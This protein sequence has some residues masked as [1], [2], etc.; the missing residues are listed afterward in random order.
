[1][2]LAIRREHQE[3]E[4]Q[5]I[6]ALGLSGRSTLTTGNL[7]DI[8]YLYTSQGNLMERTQIYLT[9][10]ERKSLRTLATRLGQSQ[11]ALIRAAVDQYVRCYQEGNR[12]NLLRQARGVWADRRDLPD[13][14]QVRR[15][16]DRL[17]VSRK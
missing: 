8:H 4:G 13:F 11:S 3:P 12:L 6:Q 14:K 1:V 16:L 15:E 10:Q 5:R 2:F 7:P 17:G 9:D